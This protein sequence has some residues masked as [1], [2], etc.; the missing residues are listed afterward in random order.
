MKCCGAGH[1][2]LNKANEA[3]DER[4][5]SQE[6]ELGRISKAPSRLNRTGSATATLIPRPIANP[7]HRLSASKGLDQTSNTD[8][9][10]LLRFSQPKPLALIKTWFGFPDALWMRREAGYRPA[11]PRSIP[12]SPTQHLNRHIKRGL[13]LSLTSLH[14]SLTYSTSI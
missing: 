14:P 8:P 3:D 13:M 6:S 9:I 10:K 5:L 12:P 4:I 11:S 7:D 1:F 2:C